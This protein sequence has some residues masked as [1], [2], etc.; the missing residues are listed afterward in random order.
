YRYMSDAGPSQQSGMML[1]A[2]G[3]VRFGAVR[4][5]LSG[6]TGQISGDATLPAHNLR[7]TAA[8]VALQTTPW[9]LLGVEAQARR[10][11]ADTNIVLQRFGG[12]FGKAIADFGGTGLQGTADLAFFPATSSAGTDP[13]GVA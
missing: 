11:A 3:A 10:E 13:I 9:L 8:T 2:T 4:L 1:G 5:G 7:I 12:I 6:E